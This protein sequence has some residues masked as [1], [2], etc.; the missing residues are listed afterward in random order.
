MADPLRLFDPEKPLVVDPD[1]VAQWLDWEQQAN[2]VGFRTSTKPVVV[3]VVHV[4]R[5]E[6]EIHV[7][8]GAPAEIVERFIGPDVNGLRG[9]VLR[10][11]AA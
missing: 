4:P 3:D 6:L 2:L 5:H 10:V 8:P 11:R 7:L 9:A 1:P